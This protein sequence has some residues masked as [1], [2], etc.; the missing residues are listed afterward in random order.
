MD[1][2][3]L[4]VVLINHP[5]VNG[6]PP[7]SFTFHPVH[8]R[9]TGTIGRFGSSVRRC[10]GVMRSGGKGGRGYAPLPRGPV[11][12]EAVVSSFAPRTLVHTLSSG[13]HNVIMC[14]SRVVKVFGTIGRCDGKRL[15]RR[16]LATFD[17]GPLSVSEYDVPV[18]V[19][20]RRPF[21]GVMNAVRAAQVRRLASGNCGSGKLVSE[22]VFICPSSRR[23]S[24]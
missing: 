12:Q 2:P 5:K 10:G 13:R 1:G 8:G 22:V 14:I 4:C 9:S 3:T 20:V 15:V 6:A 7:L 11:L 17:K 18:P 16:L 23:V 21:V 19:R 24:S